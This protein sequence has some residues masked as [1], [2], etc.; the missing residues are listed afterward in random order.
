VGLQGSSVWVLEVSKDSSKGVTGDMKKQS[1][2]REKEKTRKQ[3]NQTK[4]NGC[5]CHP[6]KVVC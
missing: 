1:K 4:I 6:V 5:L 2:E 3:E